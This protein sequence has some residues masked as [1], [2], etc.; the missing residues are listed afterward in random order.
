V[1]AKGEA[2]Q[3]AI[4]DENGNVIAHI[5]FKPHGPG[6]PSGHWHVF[7]TP[8]DPSSGHGPGKPHILPQDLPPDWLDLPPGVQPVKPIGTIK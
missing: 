1:N 3:T 2:I 7:P 5:D 8:G 4:Y 6:A